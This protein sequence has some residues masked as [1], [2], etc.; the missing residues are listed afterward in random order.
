MTLSTISYFLIASVL[1][2]I[3]PGPD[4]M[5]LL[6]KS[7]ADGTK[8]GVALS[9]GLASG[10]IFHTTLVILG[11]AA[12]I[13]ESPFAFAALKYIG[14]AYLIFLSYLALRGAMKK[15]DKLKIESKNA[16]K[17]SSYFSLFRLGLLMNILNPKVLL[18][19]LAFLPQFISSDS[20]HD[21]LQIALLGF[22]FSVQTIIIF[23][24]IA[25]TAGKI[26][27]LLLSIKNL[28]RILGFMEGAVLAIIA[29]I[30]VIE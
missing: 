30:L 12:V 25:I 14:A 7:I 9:C 29:V 16:D 15:S 20:D 2:T 17:N 21:S 5:Y 27:E 18:F 28:P 1:L 22:L 11:V 26:R 23:S 10:I 19:F 24:L 3:A 8:K 6:T 13:K 4:N